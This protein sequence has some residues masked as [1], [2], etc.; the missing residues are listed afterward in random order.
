MRL[1]FDETM[2]GTVRTPG[3]ARRFEF[4]GRAAAGSPLAM[5]GWGSFTLEGTASLQG[6]VE[7]A[8]LLPGSHLEIGLPLHRH[9][10]YQVHFRD[11]EGNQYRFFGQKTVYLLQLPRTMTTLEGT[12]FRNGAE[13]GPA[14][15]R[16]DLKQ[17]PKFLLSF[18]LQGA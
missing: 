17:L 6:V 1:H 12:V 11:G 2:A 18:S 5:L 7:N 15:L 9:L 16:F 8:P 4:T 10:R 3:G 13:L 14:T